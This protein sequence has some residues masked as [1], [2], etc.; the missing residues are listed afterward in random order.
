[1]PD[2][3]MRC[4]SAKELQAFVADPLRAENDVVAQHVYVCEGCR[5]RVE[6]LLYAGAGDLLTDVERETIRQFAKAHC[7]PMRTL[8]ERLDEFVRARQSDFFAEGLSDWRM[9]AASGQ[10]KTREDRPVEDVRFVFVSEE[11]P[12]LDDIWRAELE[13]PG[14]AGGSDPLG[15]SIRGRDGGLVGDG[16]FSIAGATLPVEGGKAEIPLDMFLLGIR[17]S[18]V[19]FQREG[20]VPVVG[21]LA[22]F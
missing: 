18:T 8:D 10:L 5:K 4:P 2:K 15:I 11:Q 17:N 1:M 21:N 14:T 22:F 9:A 19:S 16:F 6:E 12:V 13:I 20:R 7:A 3:T